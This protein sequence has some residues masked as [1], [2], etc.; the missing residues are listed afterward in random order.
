MR[1]SQ[2]NILVFAILFPVLTS[3]AQD[4]A[5]KIPE[6]AE[7]P[8]TNDPV[9]FMP[10]LLA[11]NATADFSNSSLGELL[12]WL[13]ES[14]DLVVLLD[15]DGVKEA[16]VLLGDPISD[17]IQDAPMYLLLNRLQ[18][19]GLAWF[20]EDEVLHITSKAAAE[21]RLVTQPHNVGKLIDAGYSKDALH[22]VVQAT[23]N[24]NRWEEVGGEGVITF[25]GDVMFVRQTEPIHREVQGLLAALGKHGRQT[26]TFD[27]AKHVELRK[28]LGQ[29][30][31]VSFQ[32]MPFVKAIEAVA[33]QAKIDIR[34]DDHALKQQG[35]RG[36]EP[37]SLNVKDRK[38]DT[39][40][41]ALLIDFNL[42]WILR[43]GVLWITNKPTYENHLKTAVYDVRDLCRDDSEC[44][45]LTDAIVSQTE[46]VWD[47]TGGSSSIEFAKNGT[48][49][50]Y[51]TE[52]VHNQI[53]KLLE[54]YRFALRN[55]KP[56]KQPESD[57]NHVMTVYYRLYEE[58]ASDL[59]KTLPI[60][61]EPN[62]WK[63]NGDKEAVGTILR[64]RSNPD[65]K[66]KSQ[67]MLAK[68][69]LIVRQ[70]RAIHEKIQRVINRVE[71]GDQL[72]GGVFGGGGMG[73]GGGGGF[74]G[75]FFDVSDRDD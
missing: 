71:R 19:L 56:R 58:V 1:F 2:V 5:A 26:Y 14:Q 42:T 64:V 8:K 53:L 29:T 69:V 31:S 59:Q 40:L 74:G 61:V 48:M 18:T 27:P 10:K 12:T 6:I 34:I 70:T 55:S 65:P 52:P 3:F 62:S 20:F 46:S 49:V 51:T 22:E 11:A 13:R 44:D 72:G 7:E 4:D 30:V 39:V 28:Q 54:N 23:I 47:E 68:S 25:L 67:E 36:R 50:V 66:Q 57:P 38:L 33:S 73:G 63:M 24:P 16:D 17:R 9:Q 45:A 37:V 60:L 41:Q 75:G 43:D 21:S 32:S 35:V 15:R